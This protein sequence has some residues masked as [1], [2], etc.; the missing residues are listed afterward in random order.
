MQFVG[1][2]N[3]LDGVEEMLDVI[4]DP[5]RPLSKCRP[6]TKVKNKKVLIA[7]R[8]PVGIKCKID[9]RRTNRQ[10][11]LKTKADSGTEPLKKI[12]ERV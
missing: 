9:P 3:C 2:G 1:S 12:I 5:F 10:H 4:G 11:I 6:H 8:I 7:I